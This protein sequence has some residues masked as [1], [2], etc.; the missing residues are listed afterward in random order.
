MQIKLLR[1]NSEGIAG[2]YRNARHHAKPA[3][4]L[5][6]KLEET[7]QTQLKPYD[8][9]WE[10]GH[11]VHVITT[12]DNRKLVFRPFHQ[13]GN[14]WGIDVLLKNSRTSE[15]RLMTVRNETDIPLCTEFLTQ[16]ITL[17]PNYYQ[18]TPQPVSEQG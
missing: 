13:P 14:I 1:K 10:Q 16:F 4:P 6:Q 2:T 3:V 8:F 7:F 9:I 5:I 15:V 17:Q 18:T 11:N 12:G